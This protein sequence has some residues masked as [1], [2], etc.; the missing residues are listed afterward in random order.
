MCDA[1]YIV[2][3][4]KG[5]LRQPAGIAGDF[6]VAA[7]CASTAMAIEARSSLI[8]VIVVVIAPDRLRDSPDAVTG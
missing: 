1:G 7:T 2:D 5:G 8:T 3:I 6:G 4:F